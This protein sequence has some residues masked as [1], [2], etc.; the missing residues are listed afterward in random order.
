MQFQS[1]DIQVGSSGRTHPFFFDCS[2]PT[3]PTPCPTYSTPHHEIA[4]PFLSSVASIAVPKLT[5][6]TKNSRPCRPVPCGHQHIVLNGPENWKVQMTVSFNI[7]QQNGPRSYRVKTLSP[8]LTMEAH[9]A[10]AIVTY[11]LADI[12]LKN[13]LRWDIFLAS[14]GCPES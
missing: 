1:Y 2:F 14:G 5:P 10:I 11:P 7:F 6:L 12:D 8:G 13:S 4:G 3:I 9:W